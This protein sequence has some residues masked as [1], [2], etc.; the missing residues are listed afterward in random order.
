MVHDFGG[1]GSSD[2]WGKIQ[3]LEEYDLEYWFV[4]SKSEMAAFVDV[5]N[6]YVGVQLS[7]SFYQTSSVIN[8]TTSNFWE[9]ETEYNGISPG[10]MEED[11][12][13]YFYLSRLF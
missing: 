12:S 5:L 1:K 7:K 6:K 13:G 3:T 4:P 9:Y 11:I 10:T 2:L 8:N